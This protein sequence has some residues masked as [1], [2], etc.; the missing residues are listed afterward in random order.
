MDGVWVEYNPDEHD[1]P[2]LAAAE[3]LAEA[4]T[5]EN[6]PTAAR[7]AIGVPLQQFSF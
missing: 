3:A 4:L 2:L 6:I 1:K 5:K 7:T